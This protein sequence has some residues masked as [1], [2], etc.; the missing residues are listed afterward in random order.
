MGDC[1]GELGALP[2]CKH[3]YIN[4]SVAEWQLIGEF[5]YGFPDILESYTKLPIK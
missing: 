5:M 3:V 1:G 2:G 4:F